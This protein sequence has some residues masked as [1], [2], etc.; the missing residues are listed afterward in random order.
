[1]KKEWKKGLDLNG[2]FELAQEMRDSANILSDHYKN[3]LVQ[4]Q[5]ELSQLR[6]KEL[7]TKRLKKMYENI[8][9]QEK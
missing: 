7:E 5:Q 8:K 1:M 2:M 3:K 9:K 4:S 6:H